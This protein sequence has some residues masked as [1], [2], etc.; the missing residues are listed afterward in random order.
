MKNATCHDHVGIRALH[1]SPTGNVKT[2]SA[3]RCLGVASLNVDRIL[4]PLDFS[5]A[6]SHALHYAVALAADMRAKMILMHVVEPVYV[7]GD[8]G[9]TYIPQPTVG[10][11]KADVKQMRDIAAKFIPKTLFDKAVVHRG[12]SGAPCPMPR[13]DSPPGPMT[14]CQGDTS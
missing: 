5:E 6:A 11:D 7:S 12:T 2:K 4:V 13:A 10:E 14:N 1:R 9:L 8:P 3:E